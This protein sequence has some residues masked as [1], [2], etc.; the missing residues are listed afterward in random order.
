MTISCDDA[1]TKPVGGIHA[2][3]PRVASGE[4]IPCLN[5]GEKP[6]PHDAI[7]KPCFSGLPDAA[8]APH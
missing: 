8:N 7:A 5:F 2:S 4:T 6:T 1:G 3:G